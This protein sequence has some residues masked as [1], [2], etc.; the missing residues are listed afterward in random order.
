[1]KPSGVFYLYPLFL[2]VLLS[3]VGWLLI[4]KFQIEIPTGDYFF[5]L[6]Y[7]CLVSSILLF[8]FLRGQN[9]TPQKAV[10]QTF[11]TISLKFLLYMAFLVVYYLVRKNLNTPYLIVFFVLYLAFTSMVLTIMIKYLKKR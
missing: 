9:K 3:P 8:V 10:V 1:M 2:S 5:T 4:E 6:G 7:F 11:V